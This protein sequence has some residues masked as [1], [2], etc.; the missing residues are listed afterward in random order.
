VIRSRRAAALGAAALLALASGCQTPPTRPAGSAG[1]A[2]VEAGARAVPT[3]AEP[4]VLDVPF[5][6][7]RERDCGPAALAMVLGFW[8]EPVTLVELTQ[9]LFQ[10]GLNGTLPLDLL[11]EARRR[12]YTARQLRGD[13]DTLR[14]TLSAGRPLLVFLDVGP[15][16]WAPRWHFAVAIG[17]DQE[18]VVLHSAQTPGIRLSVGRFVSAWQRADYWALDI[19]R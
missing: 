7:Q 4:V 5:V 13:L 12:G 16:G 10:P 6:P 17:L 14:A 11:L 2:A 1:A 8:G 3:P 15:A 9:R 18:A 19:T